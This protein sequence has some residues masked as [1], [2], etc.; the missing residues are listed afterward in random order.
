MKH[1]GLVVAGNQALTAMAREFALKPVRKSTA[2]K[3]SRHYIIPHTG[4]SLD[5]G[6]GG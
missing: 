5:A 6:T 2:V 1:R 3:K 4:H